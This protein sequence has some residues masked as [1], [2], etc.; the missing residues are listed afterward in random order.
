MRKM[1][2]KRRR[3]RKKYWKVLFFVPV[4]ILMTYIFLLPEGALRFAVLRSGHPMTAFSTKIEKADFQEELKEG[5]IG[6]VL[7]SPPYD[8]NQGSATENW[9]VY[10]IG[11]I[12][13]GEQ[14]IG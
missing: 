10:R 12:Y 13:W 9:V 2:K 14:Y 11:F 6:Y 8:R 1:K 4:F 3:K 7:T 5:E